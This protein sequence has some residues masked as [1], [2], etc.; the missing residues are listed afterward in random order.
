MATRKSANVTDEDVKVSSEE[1]EKKEVAQDDIRVLGD[2][3]LSVSKDGCV[4]L[5]GF[6]GY[7]PRVLWG[8]VAKAV[9]VGGV[10][11]VERDISDGDCEYAEGWFERVKGSGRERRYERV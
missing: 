9:P 5:D 10:V 1:A 4:I 3:V 2:V 6:H 8:L 7:D 11:L